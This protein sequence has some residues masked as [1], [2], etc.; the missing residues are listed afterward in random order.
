MLE[1]AA[2]S[3]ASRW[4]GFPAWVL[5]DTT[6]HI[7]SCNDATIARS[8][9]NQYGAIEV[10]F[11]VVNPPA[12]SRCVIRCPDLTDDDYSILPTSSVT[13][14]DGA[15]L[16]I[17]VTFLHPKDGY[18]VIDVFLY[19]AGPGAPSLHLLP[20]PYPVGIHS[21]HVAVLSSSGDHC[22]VVV[23]DQRAEKS[24]AVNYKLHIFSTRPNCGA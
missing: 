21:N 24:G 10:S 1:A 2:D 19:R 13:G 11:A 15:F 7:D 14:A 18:P 3:A 4:S 12:L 6:G 23:P 16:L 8:M 20:R 17:G 5:L 9:T 22:L